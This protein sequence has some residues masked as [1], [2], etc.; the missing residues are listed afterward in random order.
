MPVE[1]AIADS[2]SMASMKNSGGPKDSTICLAIG[3]I[4]TRVK[5]PM[6]PPVDDAAAAAPIA[7]PAL[8]CCAS[9]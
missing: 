6:R 3:M 9:G 4:A 7:M 2:P 8:P 5:I 1:T